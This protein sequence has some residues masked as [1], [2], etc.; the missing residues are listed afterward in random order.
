M[1]SSPS[2]ANQSFIGL[3]QDPGSRPTPTV[4]AEKNPLKRPLTF[5]QFNEKKSEER[6]GLSLQGSKKKSKK[7]NRYGHPSGAADYVMINI[8][9][10]VV[11]KHDG[12]VNPVRGKGL[13]LKIT[14]DAKSDKIL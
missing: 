6:Q 14:K 3:P 12:K 5:E 10:M 9:T 7:T 2:T 13:P 1:G 8:D 11:A 4:A